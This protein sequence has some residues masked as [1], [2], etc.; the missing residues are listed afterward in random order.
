MP[1]TIQVSD[2]TLLLL[3]KLKEELNATSYED[4]ITKVAARGERKSLAG[5]LRKYMGK[6]EK[7]GDLLKEMQ[8]ERRKD[9]RA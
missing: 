1:T 5:S 4:A 8:K 3:K 6:K 7:L 9:E 2:K